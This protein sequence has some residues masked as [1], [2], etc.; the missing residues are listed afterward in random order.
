MFHTPA[1]KNVAA[2]AGQVSAFYIHNFHRARQQ[3]LEDVAEFGQGHANRVA[4]SMRLDGLR[5][6]FGNGYVA[7]A[8]SV[9]R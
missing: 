9:A 5:T 3:A 7:G 8:R 2:P 1:H 4:A 6:P